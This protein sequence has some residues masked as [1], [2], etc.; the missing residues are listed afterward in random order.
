M[1]VLKRTVEVIR[2]LKIYL[3]GKLEMDSNNVDYN[4][5]GMVINREFVEH[6]EHVRE[7]DTHIL[8]LPVDTHVKSEVIVAQ[9]SG[10]KCVELFKTPPT[11]NGHSYNFM[12][13][14]TKH[15]EKVELMG[16]TKTTLV[17]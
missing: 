1:A 3:N 11:Q 14:P 13:L 9:N 16:S 10:E 7:N 15:V 4:L 17:P 8:I 2:T 5:H 6:V 12:L